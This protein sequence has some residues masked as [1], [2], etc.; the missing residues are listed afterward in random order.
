MITS[1][2]F[3]ILW[4]WIPQRFRIQDAQLL[5]KTYNDGY[6]LITLLNRCEQRSPL[7]LIL[8][9]KK[10]RVFGAYLSSGLERSQKFYGTGEMFVFTL[11][12]EASAHFWTNKNDLHIMVSDQIEIGSG[13]GCA[14]WIDGELLRGSSEKCETYDSEPLNGPEKNFEI[15]AVEVWGFVSH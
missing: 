6:N 14:L 1:D 10:D 9:T 12:P 7:L 8:K 11:L 2:H 3:E 13:G 5:F 4:N 15:V